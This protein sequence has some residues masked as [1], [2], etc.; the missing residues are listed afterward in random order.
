M[1]FPCLRFLFSDMNQWFESRSLGSSDLEITS[2][3][4]FAA[5]EV[6]LLVNPKLVRGVLPIAGLGRSWLDLGEHRLVLMT[7]LAGGLLSSASLISPPGSSEQ[8]EVLLLVFSAQF[9]IPISS[10]LCVPGAGCYT[11]SFLL[12]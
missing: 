5:P 9:W 4:I 2:S 8:V 11:C 12:R 6:F 7:P 10:G 1:F 3:G